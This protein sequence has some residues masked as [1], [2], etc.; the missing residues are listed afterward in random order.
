MN[1][2]IT[3]I[4]GQRRLRVVRL[5][6]NSKTTKVVKT[7]AEWIICQHGACVEKS[8]PAGGGKRAARIIK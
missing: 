2:P 1:E 8:L 6:I 5:K 7:S 4:V 3:T